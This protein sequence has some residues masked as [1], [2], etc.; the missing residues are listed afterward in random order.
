MRQ[1]PAVRSSEVATA[2]ELAPALP[3][4][5]AADDDTPPDVTSLDDA[6]TAVEN[7]IGREVWSKLKMID[8]DESDVHRV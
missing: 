6:T 8:E 1:R 3:D 4:P 2:S 7:G 5:T